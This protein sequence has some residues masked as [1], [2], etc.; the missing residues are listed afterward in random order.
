ML[1]GVTMINN[2]LIILLV[3]SSCSSIERREQIQKPTDY[4]AIIEETKA[5]L[6]SSTYPEDYRLKKV[7]NALDECNQYSLK[8]YSSYESVL[9]LNQNLEVKLQKSSQKIRDLELE[10][11]DF[12]TLKFYFYGTIVVFVLGFLA[13]FILSNW[14]SI[15]K[16]LGRVT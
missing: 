4:T 13:K 1:L 14:T 6:K 7:L 3:I 11:E 10:V 15:L 16:V 9:K 8:T 5:E 2:I 12:R